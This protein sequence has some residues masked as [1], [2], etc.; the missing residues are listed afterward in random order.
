[1]KSLI[2]SLNSKYIHSA[3]APWY[4][5]ASCGA[6]CGEVIVS[7]HTV[8]ENQDSVLSSI[9][10][11]RP[12]ITAFSCYIWNISH[13]LRL[14]S[15]LKKMLPDTVIILGGPEVSYDAA[16]LL[17]CHQFIDFIITG[18]GD[19]SFPKLIR[20]LNGR[21][22]GTSLIDEA[23]TEEA[24]TKEAA[25]IDGLVLRQAG[26]II[27]NE[28]AVIKDLDSLPSPYTDEMVASLNHKIAYFEASRGCPFS[29]SYCLSSAS[30]GTR[31]FSLSRVYSDLGK[32]VRSGVS[33]I[34][35]VDRTFNANPDRAKSIIRHILELNMSI[36]TEAGNKSTED[37]SI[38]T[39]DISK[40]TTDISKSTADRCISR[41]DECI[42]RGD[43]CIPTRDK[44]VSTRDKN[45]S[46]GDKVVCNFH[47]EVGA[48]L[49][50]EEFIKLLAD[51][52][53]GLFQLEAGVQSTNENTLSA[54]CRK[55]NIERLFKNIQKIRKMG[56]VHIHA[57]LIAG[58]PFEDYK[59]FGKSFDD[60]FVIKP[61]QLQ[62]G[63]L[64]FLKGTR[65]REQAESQ[66]F[67]YRDFAPYEILA[68]RHISGDELIKL[69]GIAELVERYY[70]SGRFALTLDFLT[71]NCFNSQAKCFNSPAN[72]FTSPFE[73]FERFYEFYKERGCLELSLSL[74]DQY[75]ILAEFYQNFEPL[76]MHDEASL[77]LEL[78]RLDYLA[79][80]S[81]GT[82]PAF[83]EGRYSSD[84]RERCMD[85][86]KKNNRINAIMPETIG[87]TPKQILKK[88]HFEQFYLKGDVSHLG[89]VSQLRGVTHLG[90]VSQLRDVSH[91]GDVS[92]LSSDTPIILIFNYFSRDI[93]T[94]RYQFY[95]VEI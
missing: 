5:K 32:L 50:D 3:L 81:T 85:F 56:N 14:A 11:H 60:V 24:F 6:G 47:F 74:K 18:E 95:M 84:F 88:V 31:Y 30:F 69:K 38:S 75:R 33:Q 73:F 21:F 16:D 36:S 42:S 35:F 20:L 7:E 83:L 40:S 78:L 62:L 58:L 37:N 79:S 19:S 90:D 51:A 67:I 9:Y 68:G 34:K 8:N 45:I 15:S 59:S 10:L 28:P 22:S 53:K 65:M 77:F 64:K 72:C 80:D 48:D 26:G 91:L 76:A 17:N 87:M 43:E 12:D 94:G 44:C 49:F 13:V 55:T 70:N 1:M 52:P 92:S 61:H 39:N 41:G 4:L 57:D 86:L 82:L 93:V 29:C 2:V 71:N 25:K 46:T 23:F 66:G 54:V 63:F 89:D 27:E